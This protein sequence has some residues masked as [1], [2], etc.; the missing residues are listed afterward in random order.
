MMTE[1]VYANMLGEHG[2]KPTANRILIL[3]TIAEA[4]RPLSMAEIESIVVT[5]DK[6]GI[7]RT[8]AL[9]RQQHLI[10]VIEAGGDSLRYE[11]CISHDHHHHDDM[12]VHFHCENCN[13]TFCIDAP[14]PHVELPDGYA[15]HSV[16][17]VVKG[18]CPDCRKCICER[19]K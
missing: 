11:L 7:S 12:H 6:S 14:I 15:M 3:R 1:S 17:Y 9:F 5:I 2:V 18:I 13:R 10:H 4:G 19:G 16:N 8:L